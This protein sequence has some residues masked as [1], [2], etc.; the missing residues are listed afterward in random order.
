MTGIVNYDPNAPESLIFGANTSS[1]LA[2]EVTD[3][4]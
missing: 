4:P 1:I 2:P 3:G